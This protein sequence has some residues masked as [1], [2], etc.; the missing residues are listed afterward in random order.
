MK[1]KLLLA[2][3]VI[4]FFLSAFAQR[5][6]QIVTAY[7]ITGAQKGSGQWSEV[8]LINLNSGEE[9]Q[10][11]YQSSKEFPVLNARTGM[12]IVKKDLATSKSFTT[13]VVTNNTND[14]EERKVI[15]IK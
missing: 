11:V 6:Q 8:R 9:I 15:I 14:I 3:V 2:F 10:P 4:S 1:R 7:A 12:R 5:R 13:T